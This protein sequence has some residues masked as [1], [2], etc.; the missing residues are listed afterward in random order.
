[1]VNFVADNGEQ[2]VE[3]EWETREEA[4]KAFASGQDIPDDDDSIESLCI[5]DGYYNRE[6]LT[7]IGIWDFSD[8]KEA[9][10]NEEI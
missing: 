7:D 2:M 3:Y 1:M 10:I 8:L 6:E 9:I 4:L 5:E